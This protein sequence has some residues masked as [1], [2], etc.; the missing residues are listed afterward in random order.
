MFKNYVDILCVDA[1]LM[2][3][4]VDALLIFWTK[5]NFNV[6]IRKKSMKAFL[7]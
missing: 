7:R 4:N 2:K 3:S 1:E 5:C 6:Y